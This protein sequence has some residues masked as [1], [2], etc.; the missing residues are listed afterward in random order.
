MGCF[1]ELKSPKDICD[2]AE[3]TLKRAADPSVT[4]GICYM[5]SLSC[6]GLQYSHPQSEGQELGKITSKLS[7]GM[8]PKSWYQNSASTSD[9][10]SHRTPGF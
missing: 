9:R 8:S 6:P 1:L 2:A 10:D 3:Y 4:D 5:A 7:W